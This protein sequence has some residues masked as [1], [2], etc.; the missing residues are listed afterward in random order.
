[1]NVSES[2]EVNQDNSFFFSYLFWICLL[3]ALIILF[4]LLIKVKNNKG[5]DFSDIKRSDRQKLKKQNIDMSDVMNDINKS[6][7]LYKILSKK[8]HPD[9]FINDP[10]QELAQHIFKQISENQKNYKKLKELQSQA[11]NE[12]SI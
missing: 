8:Y 1:L 7:E 6:K 12:L 4:L 5:S 10:R 3:A 2:S 11:E 9:R